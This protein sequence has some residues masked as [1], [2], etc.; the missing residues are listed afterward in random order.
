MFE[1]VAV[2]TLGHALDVEGLLVHVRVDVDRLGRVTGQADVGHAR[3]CLK[4]L[5]GFV[6]LVPSSAGRFLEAELRHNPEGFMRLALNDKGADEGSL[7]RI[8]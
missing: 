3:Q 5:L 8:Y 1:A 7:T 6:R 2:A 4:T